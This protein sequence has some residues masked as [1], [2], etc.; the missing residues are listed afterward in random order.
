MLDAFV[1]IVSQADAKGEFLSRSQLDVIRK[2]ANQGDT[3]LDIVNCIT[4]HYG[5]IS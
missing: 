1:R 5:E 2:M 3:R 4:A